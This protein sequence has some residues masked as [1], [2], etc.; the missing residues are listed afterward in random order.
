VTDE[1]GAGLRCPRSRRWPR[2]PPRNRGRPAHGDRGSR[3]RALGHD[4]RLVRAGIYHH[5]G[6]PP[7]R[8]RVDWSRVHVWWATIGSCPRSPVVERP[9]STRSPPSGGDEKRAARGRRRRRPR[10]RRIDPGRATP[11]PVTEAIARSAVP[12]AA[13][14]YAAEIERAD[15][16]PA[17]GDP[18]STS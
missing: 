8:E 13:V 10:R 2:R 9:A 6:R 12:R 1:D 14:R 4:W 18:R 16:R 3:G 5:L 7:L 15:P 11:E 17:N